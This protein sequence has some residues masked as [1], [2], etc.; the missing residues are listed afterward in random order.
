MLGESAAA[1]LAP[2]MAYL[3]LVGLGNSSGSCIL[4]SQVS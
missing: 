4:L 1:V 2:E 3:L